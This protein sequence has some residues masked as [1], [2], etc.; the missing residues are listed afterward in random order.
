M[1]VLLVVHQFLPN[2]YYGTEVLTRDTA[3]EMLARGHE[4]HVL[5]TDPGEFRKSIDVRYKDYD[6]G[7]LKVRSLS[8]PKYKSGGETLEAE[9]DNQ[10][11]AEHVREYARGLAPDAVHIFHLSRLSGS[12]I[13]VFGELGVPVVFTATD[14]WAICARATLSKPSGELSTG[15]DAI[16]SN[17]L[18]CREVEKLVPQAHLPEA[19]DKREF[20]R[21]LAEKALERSKGEHPSMSVVRTLLARTSYLRE[22]FNAV[23]AILVPTG[24]MYR[25][26][27]ENGVDPDLMTVSPYGMDTTG[28]ENAK[29]SRPASGELRLGFIGAINANKG[30]G[31]LLKAFA[32]LPTDAPVTLRVCG[33]LGGSPD[34]A[35]DAYALANGDPR[36]NFAGSFANEE[37]ASELG[38]IDVLVIPSTWY[39]NAPLVMYSALAAGIPVVATNLGGLAEFIR[40]GENGLLFESRNS[41]DLARQLNRLLDEPG[42]LEKLGEKAGEVRAVENS[43]DEMLALYGRLGRE[44]SASGGRGVGAGHK[45]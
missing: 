21:K 17:C 41:R 31:V 40:H 8:I 23:D 35:V 32:E 29:K 4:V 2:Y 19:E 7:G 10:L 34:Y 37:M 6:Y 12:V 39:E 44:K 24:L 45:T 14:F 38:K 26:L 33:G 3:L 5:T 36:I 18:E 28:F 43:V 22:R 42:L 11:V 16:S 13:D 1:R 15:P 27:A 25:T 30:L 20:Y 9:Y